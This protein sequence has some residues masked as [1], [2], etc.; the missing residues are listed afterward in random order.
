MALEDPRD[1]AINE[2]KGLTYLQVSMA[3]PEKHCNGMDAVRRSERK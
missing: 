2:S 3:Y 1:I